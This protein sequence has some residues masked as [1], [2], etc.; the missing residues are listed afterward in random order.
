ME[1]VTLSVEL[2]Q[3]TGKEKAGRLRREGKVPGVFYGPGKATAALCI[4]AREFRLK[5][6]GLEGSQLIQ[7]VSPLP[8]LSEELAL[9]KEVQHHPVTNEVLHIDF[10]AV[11][12][13]KPIEATVPLHFIGKAEGVTAG[14]ILQP[15]CREIT[16]ECLPRDIPQFIAVEVSKLAIHQSIYI[17]EL[18]LPAGA[19]AVYDTNVPVVTVLPPIAVETKPAEAAAE[20]AAPTA[21]PATGTAQAE[22]EKK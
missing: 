20:A 2:R 5:L 15:L 6:A 13:T 17:E 1:T 4:D 14:G 18:V 3:G 22:A 16:V 21:A 10:Y 9:L 12:V 19:K 7:F 11:D 8:E